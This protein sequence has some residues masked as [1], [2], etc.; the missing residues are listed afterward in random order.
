MHCEDFYYSE[1]LVPVIFLLLISGLLPLKS[2]DTQ[3]NFNFVRSL[4]VI[5]KTW[6]MNVLIQQLEKNAFLP[7]VSGV[8]GKH[9]LDHLGREHH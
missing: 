5:S 6:N 8:F 3:Y 1:C 9:Y 7:M 4:E 2:D